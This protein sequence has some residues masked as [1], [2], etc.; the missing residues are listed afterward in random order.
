MDFEK[1]ILL[2]FKG[3]LRS[4]HRRDGET[5][6]RCINSVGDS[7]RLGHSRGVIVLTSKH[8]GVLLRFRYG[9]ETGLKT[10]AFQAQG[11]LLR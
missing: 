10:G 4:S 7:N 9:G 2:C 5:E 1:C 6:S 8:T 11:V 3:R